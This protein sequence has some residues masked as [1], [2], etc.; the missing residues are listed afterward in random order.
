MSLQMNELYQRYNAHIPAIVDEISR[1]YRR[2]IEMN[3]EKALGAVNISA[4]V[5]DKIEG[6]NAK[7][8]EDMVFGVMKRELR[9]I[10]YLGAA[11]GFFM[12][13]INILF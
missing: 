13:F 11:L 9:A 12:G 1:I 2:V 10:V 6:L 8:L 4:I 3:L 5:I 7:E